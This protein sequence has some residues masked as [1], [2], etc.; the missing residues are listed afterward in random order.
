MMLMEAH[1]NY[2]GELARLKAKK[3]RQT[4][5]KIE[6]EGILDEATLEQILDPY[7]MTEPGISAK[8]LLE[9]T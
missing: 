3:L 2:D 4:K 9:K 8:H 5:E 1:A 6:K 7:S